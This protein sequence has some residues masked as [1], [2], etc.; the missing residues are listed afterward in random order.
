MVLDVHTSKDKSKLK[1]LD[2]TKK[3]GISLEGKD[4][5]LKII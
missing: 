2:L 4:E 3:C 1:N 5:G